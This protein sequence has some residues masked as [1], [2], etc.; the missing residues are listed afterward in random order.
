MHT[1][2]KKWRQQPPRQKRRY[3]ETAQ[4]F[5]EVPRLSALQLEALDWVDRICNDPAWHLSF[6][7][8]AGDMQI[9]NNF[10]ILHSRTAYVDFEAQ[11]RR[12]L[13]LRIWMT[14]PDG[15]ALP[16]VFENTREFG[17]TFRRRAVSV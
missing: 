6:D 14:L 12:R 11:E 9:G 3:I 5:S 8:Q 16:Q 13:L 15:R 2:G 10:S 4:R 1:A 7:M 17:Q